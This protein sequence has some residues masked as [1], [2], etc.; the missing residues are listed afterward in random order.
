[1]PLTMPQWSDFGNIVK[2]KMTAKLKFEKFVQTKENQLL[3]ER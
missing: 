2:D 3:T 1:M